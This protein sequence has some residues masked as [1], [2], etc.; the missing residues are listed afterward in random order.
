MG[1]SSENV[2]TVRCLV[3]CSLSLECICTRN[4]VLRNHLASMVRVPSGARSLAVL[5]GFRLLLF[6][7]FL[8][9]SPLVC[10]CRT[11][12]AAGSAAVVYLFCVCLFL[13][14]FPR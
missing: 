10:F 7:L 13:Y 5:H 2:W 1:G 6:L 14:S 9:F 12:F 8:R 4:F 3:I 11:R